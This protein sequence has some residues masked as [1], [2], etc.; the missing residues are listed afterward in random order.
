M[1]LY[2]QYDLVGKKEDVS[3]VIS[4]ISPTET[5]FQSLIGSEKITQVL[6]QWQE[7]ALAAVRDNKNAEGFTASDAT[8]AATTLRSNSTQILEKT[9]KVSG[10]ADATSSYGRAKE[11]AYQLAKAAAEVK[12]DLEHAMVGLGLNAAVNTAVGTA[13]EMASAQSQISTD[14]DSLNGGTPRALTEALVL[15]VD[16]L[17]YEAGSE[18]KIVM[19][20]PADSLIFAGFT[21]ASGRYRTFEGSE[22][23]VVNV[24]NLYVSP[25]GE[26]K[27]VLNRFIK[28]TD[29]LL[30]DPAHWKK[31]VLR[32]WTRTMLA[33][34]GDNE[35]HMLVGEFSLKHTNQKASG[36]VG[37]LS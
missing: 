25:F 7:D 17:I 1:A 27:V 2:S 37:D 15:A 34:T 20:K 11:T 8:L 19:I 21:G 16:Q 18:A 23:K 30:F 31:L 35:M 12:R 9:I 22:T 26:K 13:R 24:V 4:M 28:S 29:A 33:K 14:N 36:Y 10:T 32:P 3:D 5:P 6:H